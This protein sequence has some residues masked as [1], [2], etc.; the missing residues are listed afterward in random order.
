MAGNGLDAI[1]FLI[2]CV[3]D[4]Y[5]MVLFVRLILAWGN[6]DYHH[7]LTQFVVKLTNFII[8]PM[9]KYIPDFRGIETATIILILLVVLLKY[10]VLT[11]LTYGM[12][13][14]GGLL[15]LTIG[16]TLRLLLETLSIALILLAILSWMQ[17]QSPVYLILNKLT[18]PITRPLQRLIPLIAG[19]DITPLV[20]IV[21]L[22]LLVILI[23]NPIIAKGLAIAIG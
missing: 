1:L 2:S 5:I 7:P 18:A 10:L 6:A 3:F 17:P 15:I 12:P 13:N 23:A 22:Q 4:F 19:V 9:K 11:L 21:I 8:K 14:L 16:D 20:A